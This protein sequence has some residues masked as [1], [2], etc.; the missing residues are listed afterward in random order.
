MWKSDLVYYTV[1]IIFCNK[2]TNDQT[3]ENSTKEAEKRHIDVISILQKVNNS[4]SC[5]SSFLA[6]K[7]IENDF[8]KP[9]FKCILTKGD[10]YRPVIDVDNKSFE[11]KET[12]FKLFAENTK[13]GTD[14]IPPSVELLIAH[15]LNSLLTWS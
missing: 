3:S 10:Q 1:R 11:I 14:K 2:P 5:D 8:Y 15:F 6:S 7:D 4:N 13:Y 12:I 9:N